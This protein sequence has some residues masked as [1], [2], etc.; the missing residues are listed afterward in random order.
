MS[1]TG[2]EARRG[3]SPISLL[4]EIIN[5]ISLYIEEYKYP[6]DPLEVEWMLSFVIDSS[7]I[8]QMIDREN[9]W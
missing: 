2:A 7:H 9:M 4:S 1:S 8:G 3:L 5:L 6:L